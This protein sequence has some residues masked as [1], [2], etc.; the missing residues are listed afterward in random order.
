MRLRFRRKSDDIDNR[1]K[2]NS[3][4]LTKSLNEAIAEQRM[5]T[6]DLEE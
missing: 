6:S 5:Q 4:L 1:N 3:L 2:L